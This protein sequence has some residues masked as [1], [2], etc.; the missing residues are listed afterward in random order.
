MAFAKKDSSSNTPDPG[1]GASSIQVMFRDWIGPWISLGYLEERAPLVKDTRDRIAAKV[2]NDYGKSVDLIKKEVGS[3]MT[4]R[5]VIGNQRDSLVIHE[6]M[7]QLQVNVPLTYQ[8]PDLS[9]AIQQAVGF[10]QTFLAAQT[11]GFALPAANAFDVITDASTKSDAR[12]N[13]LRQQVK[14]AGD[15]V[16]TMQATIAT[17]N[18]QVKAAQ[19]AISPLSSKVDTVSTQVQRLN[20]LDPKD[21]KDRLAEVQGLRVSVNNLNAVIKR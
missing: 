7:D 3:I 21:I 2:T 4:D 11:T 12:V 5:G 6:A 17:L 18:G 15:T 14:T 20:D 1:L 9:K 16:T 19:A 10:Q 13:D 8:L